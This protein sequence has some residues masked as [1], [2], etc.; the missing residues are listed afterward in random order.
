MSSVFEK[1]SHFQY[2]GGEI[3][4]GEEFYFSGGKS[5]LILSEFLGKK[6]KKIL[7]LGGNCGII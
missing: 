3:Y 4:L 2:E 7:L 6:G 5:T 1:S